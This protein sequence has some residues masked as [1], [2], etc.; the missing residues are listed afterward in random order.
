[1]SSKELKSIS[2]TKLLQFA[3]DTTLILSDLNSANALFS[4]LEEFEKA[5]GLKLNVKKTEAMWIGSLRSCQDQPLGVKWQ[6]CVKFLG[7]YITYDIKLLVEKNFKQRLK[8]IENVINIWKVR[9]LSIHGKVTIIKAFLLSKM[10]YP[11]SV[12]TTP[13]EIIKEFNRLVFHFLW[14]GKDKVTRRSTYASYDSG[15]VNMVDYENIVKALRLSLLKRITD[16]GCI[17]S[18]KLYLCDLL[19]SYGGLFIFGLF[20]FDCNYAVNNLNI[21]PEFYYELLLWWSELRDLVDCDGEYKYII[22]NNREIKIEGKSV[23]YKRYLSKG[24]K[25]T[26][27]LLYDKT[28]IDSFNTFVGEKLLNSNF[29]T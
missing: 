22:W 24:V 6:T 9:G 8:K 27:D 17:S 11:S 28:N 20:I 21:L 25:H 18:W 19:S 26:K 2:W 3:D 14:N 29:L 10:I 23:L 1:M 12:L 7:I 15:G 13:H 4:L 5:S 16:E